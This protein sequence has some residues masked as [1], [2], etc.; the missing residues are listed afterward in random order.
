MIQRIVPFAEGAAE[1]RSLI[2]PG[3][4][5]RLA[6]RC[7][8]WSRWYGRKLSRAERYKF[9][10]FGTMKGIKLVIY[11]QHSLKLCQSWPKKR[12]PQRNLSSEDVFP[13]NSLKKF[14]DWDDLDEVSP[15]TDRG[16]EGKVFLLRSRL[17]STYFPDGWQSWDFLTQW[18]GRSLEAPSCWSINW[19]AFCLTSIEKQRCSQVVDS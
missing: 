17:R 1:W 18:K 2:R 4:I 11:F 9:G 15:W 12:S 7:M 13:D 19:T 8:E 6:T 10:N 16:L 14:I 5:G 3:K